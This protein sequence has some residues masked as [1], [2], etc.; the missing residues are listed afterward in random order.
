LLRAVQPMQAKRRGTAPLH[1]IQWGFMYGLGVQEL[2]GRRRARVK[3]DKMEDKGEAEENSPVAG[4][5]W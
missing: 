2:K 3:L 4:N 1:Q 5:Y